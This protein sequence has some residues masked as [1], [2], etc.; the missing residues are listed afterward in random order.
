MQGMLQCFRRDRKP[1]HKGRSRIIQQSM[2][3]E[4][5]EIVEHTAD[6]SIR[7]RGANLG[8]LFSNAAK[9]M[10]MLMVDDPEALDDGIERSLEL[11]GYD[12]ESLLVDWL[13]ELAYLAE[14]EQV[15]FKETEIHEIDEKRLSATV[16]GGEAPVLDK[17]IKAVTFHNL[18]IKE[19]TS[20]LEVTIVFD[21]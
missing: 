5:I 9:G 18:A 4:A 3:R 8:E 14:M 12:S 13:N 19:T 20:G 16:R 7:V 10:A 11:K 6:W 21:V 17:H 1:R 15:V 2:S